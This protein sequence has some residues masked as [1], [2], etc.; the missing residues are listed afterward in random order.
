MELLISDGM[1][2]FPVAEGF[3]DTGRGPVSPGWHT[4]ATVPSP[5]TQLS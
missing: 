3:R 4:A 5:Q 1:M 2:I